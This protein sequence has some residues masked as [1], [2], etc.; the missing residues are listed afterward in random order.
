MKSTELTI[1]PVEAAT[2]G[3]PEFGDAKGVE[4]HFGICKSMTF[5]L[6]AEKK[7]RGISIRKAGK[8]RGKRLF[9]FSSIREFLLS[10]VDHEPE[11]TAVINLHSDKAIKSAQKK[12]SKA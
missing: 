4:Q 6:L 5:R 10:N 8:M 3:K 9:D 7:I 1:A 11:K 12:S 2:L